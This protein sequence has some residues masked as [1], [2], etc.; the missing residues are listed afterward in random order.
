MTYLKNRAVAAAAGLVVLALAV[1]NASAFYFHLGP[2]HIGTA[3]KVYQVPPP[4]PT[5]PPETAPPAP[6]PDYAWVNGYWDWN[7][8][9]YVWVPGYWT[10]PPAGVSIWVAPRYDSYGYYHRGYWRQESRHERHERHE[11]HD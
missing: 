6:G 7:G 8:E 9:Q 4:P 1:E 2:L 5:T 10:Q 3:P 11:H